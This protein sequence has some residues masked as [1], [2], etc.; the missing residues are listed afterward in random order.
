VDV[1]A[2]QERDAGESDQQAD[3]AA[4]VEPVMARRSRG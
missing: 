3:D 1:E 4:R 2:D